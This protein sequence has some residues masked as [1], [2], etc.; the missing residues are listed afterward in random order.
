[1]QF[2]LNLGKNYGDKLKSR[3]VLE[4][5]QAQ[6]TRKTRKLGLRNYGDFE[7]DKVVQYSDL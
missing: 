2:Q 6:Q 5:Y 4:H 3:K 1:M 7:T